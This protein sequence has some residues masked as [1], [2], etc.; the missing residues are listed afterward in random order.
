MGTYLSVVA[1]A[2]CEDQVNEA[3]ASIDG[4]ED[5][6]L[7]YSKKIIEREIQYIH[8]PD[9]EGQAHLRQFMRS[10]ED[11]EKMF[12]TLKERTGLV[13]LS[14][15][16]DDDQSKRSRVQKIIDFVTQ[17]Q[18]LF[19]RIVGLDDAKDL[20]FE[21][22]FAE[23]VILS[24]EEQANWVEPEPEPTFDVLA[25]GQSNFYSRCVESNRPDL[26][27]AYLAFEKAPSDQTW[28]N[29]RQKVIP[30]RKEAF[31][32]VWQLVEAQAAKKTGNL[33]RTEPLFRNGAFP[34][35]FEVRQVLS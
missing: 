32:T 25:V 2:G 8:S 24:P 10:V 4:L 27:A 33:F 15:L 28:G 19:D 29:L 11:W 1:K 16:D 6:F 3:F 26:W 7:V 17:N 35:V 22:R 34:S 14:G 31:A 5:R 9:G 18:F 20:G 21:C 12:P 13:K 23:S 30:W